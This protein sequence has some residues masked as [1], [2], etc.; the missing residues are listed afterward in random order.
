[1]QTNQTAE[2]PTYYSQKNEQPF[3]DNPNF[4]ASVVRPEGYYPI[5][6]VEDVIEL[7]NRGRIGKDAIMILK[8]IGDALCLN[9]G[10]IKRIMKLA[11]EDFGTSHVSRL[12]RKLEEYGI[13]ERYSC[14]LRF[15]QEGESAPRHSAPF[16]LGIAGIKY[17]QHYYSK[18][19]FV[20]PELWKE[21]NNAIQRYVAINEIRCQLATARKL[22]DWSW[23]PSIGN[24]RQYRPPLAVAKI[25]NQSASIQMIFE[26]AQA[27]QRFE[28]HLIERL[29]LYQQLLNR[30]QHLVIDKYEPNVPQIFLISCATL[31]MASHLAVVLELHKYAF[32]VWFVLDEWLDDE[33][34]LSGAFARHIVVD[35]QT[36][37][38]RFRFAL[39]S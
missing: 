12:L 16:T 17:L 22:M 10:Q 4:E 14:S 33:Y 31:Q 19:T 37:L 6:R 34:G 7:V 24:H 26:R 3:W 30:D 23:H 20:R 36:T 28:Q 15:L 1:M 8:V 9:E 18:M 5:T 32:P 35:G 2:K 13:V 39:I 21:S 29:K 11:S 25:K 27:S 38:E